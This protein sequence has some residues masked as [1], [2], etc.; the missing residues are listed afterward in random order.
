MDI[1]DDRAARRFHQMASLEREISR[2]SGEI[3]D[4]KDH[5]KELRE[6]RDGLLLK[7]RACARDQGELSLFDLAEVEVVADQPSA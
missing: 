1:P 5:L 3:A 6:A 2:L 7:L 4:C